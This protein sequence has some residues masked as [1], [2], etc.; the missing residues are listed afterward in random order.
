MH[1]LQRTR[2]LPLN[3]HYVDRY[4]DG[5][6]ILD[7]VLSSLVRDPSKHPPEGELAQRVEQYTR[8]EEQ[9]MDSVLQALGYVIDGQDTIELI[10]SRYQI[11]RVG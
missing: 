10:T 7:R 11:E 6:K 1:V 4:L 8:T 3:R 9:R 5:M 2:V